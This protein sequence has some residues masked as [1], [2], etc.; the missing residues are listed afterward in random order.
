MY[1]VSKKVKLT[2][3]EKRVE[4]ARGWMEGKMGS[5]SSMSMKLQLSKINFEDLLYN[6]VPIDN[7]MALRI[8]KMMKRI[9]LMLS[10]LIA[11]A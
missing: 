4:V 9:N 8:L 6:I 7:N 5:F 11:H 2:E 10:I 1:E 3:A